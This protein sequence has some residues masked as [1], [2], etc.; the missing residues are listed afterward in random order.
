MAD[1]DGER[2]PVTYRSPLQNLAELSDLIGREQPRLATFVRGALVGAL[3]GA[4]I[5]GSSLWRRR[6]RRRRRP[7]D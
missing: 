4:A 1:D 3:V 7:R 6:R 2:E 5:A